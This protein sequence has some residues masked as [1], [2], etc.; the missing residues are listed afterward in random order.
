M[1]VNEAQFFA[2][3][4]NAYTNAQSAVEQIRMVLA[5]FELVKPNGFLDTNKVLATMKRAQESE[6]K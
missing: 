4:I 5:S 3:L 6:N 2:R 1:T